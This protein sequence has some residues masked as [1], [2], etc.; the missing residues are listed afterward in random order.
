MPASS[1]FRS[2]LHKMETDTF[3]SNFT[4][5]EIYGCSFYY[6]KDFQSILSYEKR[7]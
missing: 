2:F 5:H 7:L 6:N 1:K 4:V 3:Q